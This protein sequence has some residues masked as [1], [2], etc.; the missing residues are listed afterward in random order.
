TSLSRSASLSEMAG[1]SPAMTKESSV[2]YVRGVEDDLADAGAGSDE[3]VGQHG[4]RQRQHA[5]DDDPEAP[6]RG[7]LQAHA[8]VGRRVA[9][10]PDDGD[11]VVIEAV[12]V[13]RHDAAAVTAGRHQAAVTRQP[14]E[15]LG[16]EVGIADVLE[17]HIDAALLGDAQD[18]FG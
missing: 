12:D 18:F 3:L 7:R 14:G 8:R 5:V 15:R 1:S 2:S 9:G 4:L 11:L 6:L 10:G 13:E 16:K 17:H